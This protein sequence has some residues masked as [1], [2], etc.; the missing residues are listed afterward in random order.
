MMALQATDVQKPLASV[1]RIAQRGN[2]VAF[3]GER[4]LIYIEGSNGKKV[5]LNEKNGIYT[6]PVEFL[7]EV[8]NEDFTRQA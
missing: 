7:Q 5:M 3:G 1:R 6:L 2:D 4:E 8:N